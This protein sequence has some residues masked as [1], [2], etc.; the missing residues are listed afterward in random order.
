MVDGPEQRSHHELSGPFLQAAP[1]DDLEPVRQHVR[2]NLERRFCLYRRSS[3][4]AGAPHAWTPFVSP[5][6]APG[7]PT[8]TISTTFETRLPRTRLLAT[9]QPSD[10]RSRR[11]LDR[12]R[13]S[14]YL[15]KR[16]R[17]SRHS[18]LKPS[19]SVH[20]TRTVCSLWIAPREQPPRIPARRRPRR[21]PE[22]PVTRVRTTIE[23]R[24]VRGWLRTALCLDGERGE[25]RIE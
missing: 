19:T 10:D 2:D 20:H 6:P 1:E 3:N 21:P 15:R 5:Q 17:E 7:H 16:A 8:R 24:P 11:S 22:P 9:R 25:R 13:G 14:L 4:C 12:S 23:W 18:S